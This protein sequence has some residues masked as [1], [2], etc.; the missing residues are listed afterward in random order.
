MGIFKLDPKVRTPKRKRKGK[1]QDEI[2]TADTLEGQLRQLT[3]AAY[4]EKGQTHNNS[5]QAV[6]QRYYIYEALISEYP[7]LA[8]KNIEC[9]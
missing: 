6:L 8:D 2:R 9:T 5:R 3:Q 4:T 1:N 7:S